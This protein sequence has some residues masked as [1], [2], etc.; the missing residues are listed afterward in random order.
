MKPIFNIAVKRAADGAKHLDLHLHGVIDGGW[1]QEDGDGDGANV[2][3]TIAKLAEHRDAGTVHAYINSVGGSAF[4]G[5]ALYNALSQ[6]P[7]EVTCY[8]QGLAASAASLVAMA[9]NTVMCT[10]SMMMIHSPS[11]IA[12]GNAA[13]LRKQA[14]VLD[15]VQGA[16]AEIYTKKTGKSAADV[17]ALLDG[18]TWMTAAEA[19]AA[20]FAN[21]TGDPD[22]AEEGDEDPNAPDEP[23][24]HGADLVWRGVAFPSAQ[25]PA[26]I[27]A[28]AKQPAP[29][30]AVVPAPVTPIVNRAYLA[31]KAPDLL[32]ALMAEGHAA[33]V[34]DERARL[35]AIDA[36]AIAGCADLVADTKY[37]A[38][39]GTAEA[40]CVAVVKAGKVAGADLLAQRRK[41]S[42]VLSGVV[43]GTPR[44]NS[45]SDEETRRTVQSMLAHSAKR[46]RK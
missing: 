28:M 14:D 31:E 21:E 17:N 44:S 40:L 8:V 3:D 43:V 35:Q 2:A 4:A 11:T 34:V 15:K 39:P 20:G 33:G 37:G 24:M 9:G 5:V 46:G 18:E 30:V 29:V 13:E 41:E 45:S 32:A 7:G 25:L 1:T 6:H 38:A 42:E 10:G 19:V 22:E 16:L 27:L 26:Q 12:M 23:T 36:L